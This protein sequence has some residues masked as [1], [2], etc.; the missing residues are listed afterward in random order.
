MPFC[1]L[2]KLAEL[3]KARQ[4]ER[5]HHEQISALHAQAR[6]AKSREAEEKKKVMI[7]LAF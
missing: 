6:D 4:A 2:Q 5:K 3:D 1:F 7:A